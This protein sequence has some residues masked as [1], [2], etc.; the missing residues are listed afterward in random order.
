M[1]K[2]AQTDPEKNSNNLFTFLIVLQFAF[3]TEEQENDIDYAALGLM[4]LEFYEIF[5]KNCIELLENRKMDQEDWN[6]LACYHRIIISLL[7]IVSN[8]LPYKLF[9]ETLKSYNFVEKIVC[10]LQ[11]IENNTERRRLKDL[12]SPMGDKKVFGNVKTILIEIITYLVHNDKESQDLVRENGGL[13][14]ILNNCNLDVNEPFIRER[15]ILCLK[16]LLENNAENQAFVASLEPK[17]V[18]VTQENEKI[19]EKSG[20]EVEI[21]DGKVKLKKTNDLIGKIEG[22]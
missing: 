3:S 10:F 13:I 19:L 2:S 1:F 8:L 20:Y 16:Y 7:D 5:E 11:I 12:E 4:C 17:K 15:C 18:E 9:L 14:L 22:N 6:K 21:V